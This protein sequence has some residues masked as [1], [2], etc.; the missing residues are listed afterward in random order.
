[1]LV[2]DNAEAADAGSGA[3]TT[4]GAVES[5]GTSAVNPAGHGNGNGIESPLST[6]RESRSLLSP[7][8]T[9]RSHEKGDVASP[10][11][12]I[13]P[14]S[15]VVVQEGPV[16]ENSFEI[17]G[18][19][20]ERARSA[21]ASQS[22]RKDDPG[23][24]S[25][26]LSA[27]A[28]SLSEG[29]DEPSLV[30]NTKPESSPTSPEPEVS[31]AGMPVNPKTDRAAVEQK[32]EP[33]CV[34]EEPLVDIDLETPKVETK[35]ISN[36]SPGSG[37]LLDEDTPQ[38]EVTP[39]RSG[40]VN[41]K[42]LQFDP[43]PSAAEAT[44]PPESFGEQPKDALSTPCEPEKDVPILASPADATDG[45]SLR[46]DGPS[47][48]QHQV[49]EN[50][51]EFNVTQEMEGEQAKAASSS[52]GWDASP[53]QDMKATGG[54]PG[55]DTIPI[56]RMVYETETH[57]RVRPTPEMPFEGPLKERGSAFECGTP[58]A[59][60]LE[61]A[62]NSRN[63]EVPAPDR[64]QSRGFEQESGS[65]GSGSWHEMNRDDR[66]DGSGS[67]EEPRDAMH[68]DSAFSSRC[69]EPLLSS[70][71]DRDARASGQ[72]KRKKAG[73]PESSNSRSEDSKFIFG[74]PNL[75]LPLRPVS[76]GQVGSQ[77]L[78]IRDAWN[79]SELRVQE[80]FNMYD[81]DG[82][83]SLDSEE[84][85]NLLKDYNDGVEP[86]PDEI[87]WVS[88]LSDRNSD[89]VIQVEE[90]HYALRSWHGYQNLPRD[91]MRLFAEF[92]FEQETTSA[93]DVGFIHELLLELNGGLP[94]ASE[95]VS[96]VLLE[97]SVLA[98]TDGPANRSHF[99]GA[100]S[101]WYVHVARKRTDLL[102]LMGVALRRTIGHPQQE[103]LLQG[104]SACRA[105]SRHIA[106]FEARTTD[107]YDP[108]TTSNSASEIS[109]LGAS[110]DGLLPRQYSQGEPGMS[111]MEVV[112]TLAPPLC[113]AIGAF[114]MLVAPFIVYPWLFHVGIWYGTADCPHDLHGLMVVFS[115]LGMTGCALE[116]QRWLEKKPK[117]K[118]LA[119]LTDD[120]KSFITPQGMVKLGMTICILIGFCWTVGMG[121][122]ES[123][124][125]G[126]FFSWVS[127]FI[128]VIYPI[129][130]LI[131]T[132]IVCYSA[133]LALLAMLETENRLQSADDPRN[134]R[135]SDREFRTGSP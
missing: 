96:W 126:S 68:K 119:V 34:S 118:G 92:D 97:A 32:E 33:D 47:R 79:I 51:P 25:P 54:S 80:I 94:V 89:G 84:F 10:P 129:I 73:E 111:R 120:N 60:N 74:D 24:Q 5:G 17:P 2:E 20:P 86:S 36:S 7:V 45:S 102:L 134:T 58:L 72:S 14:E 8:S 76:R 15:P 19:G 128:W 62:S 69:E 61:K 49:V 43:E 21:S 108:L 1:M 13:V 66:S 57:P 44:R 26:Q 124:R 122:E 100:I 65:D 98:D 83:E 99:L 104:R 30:V 11:G 67:Q 40:D 64:V 37:S 125:C 78:A 18:S 127:F 105:V 29:S 123:E 114:G 52:P 107:G 130:E 22:P 82:N 112:K 103:L 132:L 77:R 87:E 59:A 6:N 106:A 75:N 133:T 56:G 117:P 101:A 121:H 42:T 48:S 55:G 27:R 3:P 46:L 81:T 135:G 63:P 23:R 88:K 9:S 71:R 90:L 16:V 35:R 31:F 70:S 12:Q 53:S 50:K 85:L 95:E 113:M 38:V 41:Q 4:S 91:A 131:N 115:L 93:V 116:V 109:G 110:R 39:S 28:R